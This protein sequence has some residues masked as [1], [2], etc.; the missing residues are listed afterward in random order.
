MPHQEIPQL[1][2]AYFAAQNTGA[3]DVMLGS[4]AE[5]A[6][7]HDEGQQHRGTSAI[8]AWMEHTTQKYQPKVEVLG[9]TETGAR[10]LADVSVSGTFPGS[11]VRLL[12]QFTLAADRITSLEIS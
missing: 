9:A 6:I 5:D 11:P 4:F 1:L 7:V 10:V 8:R 12:Y 2:A 3:V